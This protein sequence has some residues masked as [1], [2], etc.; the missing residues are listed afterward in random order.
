MQYI[1][2][3]RFTWIRDKDLSKEE[4]YRLKYQTN[5]DRKE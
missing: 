1:P 4:F 5:W 3:D 2:Q